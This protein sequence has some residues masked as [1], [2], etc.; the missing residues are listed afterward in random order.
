MNTKI[1]Q[2]IDDH[3]NEMVDVLSTL[4]AIP[5]VKGE[6]EG[7]MPFGKEPAKALWKMLEICENYGFTVKNHENYVGTID[8]YTDKETQLGVLCHLDVVPEG[9]TG[10]VNPPYQLTLS[11]G[12]L[13]GRGS[14][15]DK[16]PAVAVLFALRAIKESGIELSKNVRLLVGTDEECGSS[17]LRYYRAKEA[18]PPYVFTPDATYPVIN[19]EK[20]RISGKF[21]KTIAAGSEKTIVSV[22]GGVAVNAVPEKATAVVKGFTAD[23]L[24]AVKAALPEDITMDIEITGDTAML[25]VNGKAAH[26]S[27]PQTGKNSVT[28]LMKVIGTMQTDDESAAFFASIA[29]IFAYGESNGESMG[30][31]AQ[32]EKSGALTFVFSMID[33]ENG[34]F[35][36]AFDIR[37]PICEC[38]ASV[39]AKIEN[40]IATVGLDMTDFKGVEPHYVDENSDFIKTLLSVYTDFTGEEGKCLAIGGGTY[41]HGIEGGVAFGAEFIGEDNHVHGANEYISLE[42]FI[43]NA[44]IFAEAILRICG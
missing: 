39:R 24:D 20:G 9:T 36:S 15:D 42:K 43:L 41:V 12:K 40:T 32:D 7:D 3:A 27:A 5:S 23:E 19:L 4:V 1:H 29:K 34:A 8:M 33:Y 26:A 13:Y 28:A 25:T 11:D 18:L 35:S 14:S 37:F 31:K 38:V 17:D 6:P 2:Y 22:K 44:K 21:I 16:G 10:W 30:I